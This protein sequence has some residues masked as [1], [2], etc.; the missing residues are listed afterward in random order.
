MRLDADFDAPQAGQQQVHLKFHAGGRAQAAPRR[1]DAHFHLTAGALQQ[2]PASGQFLR[3][4]QA[5][6]RQIETLAA[7]RDFRVLAERL[8][9]VSEEIG[10]AHLAFHDHGAAFS[11]PSDGVGHFAADAGLFRK[12]H[13]ATVTAQPVNREIYQLRVG[14]VA[15]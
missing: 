7:Q 1:L 4:N 10:A 8:G 2:P 11:L 14:H 9:A 13:A 6:G 5:G 12:H 3:R 15:D